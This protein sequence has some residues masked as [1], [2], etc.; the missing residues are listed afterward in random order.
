MPT[1]S[2]GEKKILDACCG[3]RMFWFDKRHRNALYIDNRVMAPTKQTNGAT[4]EVAPDTVM[5]FRK[6]DFPDETFSLVVF[7]PPQIIKRGGK[8]SWMAEKYGEL[9]RKTWKTDLAAGFAECFRVLKNE[10]VLIFK[11][12]E[13][14]IVLSEVLALTQE[15]PLFGHK[16]GKQSKTHWVTFMKLT[17]PMTSNPLEKKC[18]EKCW[19]AHHPIKGI[20]PWCC[21]ENCLCHTPESFN[22]RSE[23]Q[24]LWQTTRE[25]EG[26]YAKVKDFISSVEQHAIRKTEE[27]V[28]REIL[29]LEP[30]SHYHITLIESYA[31][32]KGITINSTE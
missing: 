10:G 26:K 24:R 7:D 20:G 12:N 8:R 14:D 3:S 1:S 32:S 15:K 28:V 25:H 22:W 9:D 5:D 6:M 17:N 31:K 21:N 13:T 27:R 11:W 19:Y 18:C 23:L 29:S 30:M 4:I 16:S 2:Q